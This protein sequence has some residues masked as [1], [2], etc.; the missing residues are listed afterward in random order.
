MTVFLSAKCVNIG[1]WEQQSSVTPTFVLLRSPSKLKVSQWSCSQALRA[2]TD[3]HPVTFSADNART[4]RQQGPQYLVSAYLLSCTIHHNGPQR[5]RIVMTFTAFMRAFPSSGTTCVIQEIRFR[6]DFER[7]AEYG[8][9]IRLFSGHVARFD[10]ECWI[11]STCLR[12]SWVH[13]SPFKNMYSARC[14]PDFTSFPRSSDIR[15]W[16]WQDSG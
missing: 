7:L 6:Q 9:E 2:K 15:F 4:R 11:Q 8:N 12:E 13:N 16:P 14:R 5:T 1:I 10:A 3:D